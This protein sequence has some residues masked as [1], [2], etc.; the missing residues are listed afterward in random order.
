MLTVYKGAFASKDIIHNLIWHDLSQPPNAGLYGM[1][2]EKPSKMRV[3]RR[4]PYDLSLVCSARF[5]GWCRSFLYLVINGRY[6][7]LSRLF[8]ATS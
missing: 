5:L 8:R 6:Q 2:S 1:N 7:I 3:A 4:P